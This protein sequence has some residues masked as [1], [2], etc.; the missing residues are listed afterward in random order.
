ME[1]PPAQRQLD[2]REP[3]IEHGLTRESRDRLGGLG[4]RPTN[5]TTS[6][7]R[8]PIQCNPPCP[9]ISPQSPRTHR[10]VGNPPESLKP[11]S[12]DADINGEVRRESGS[13]RRTSSYRMSP[14]SADLEGWIDRG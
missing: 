5:P 3:S 8:K 9:E 11:A 2:D 7:E 14:R 1:L 13:P 10:H 6:H 4:L 12:R